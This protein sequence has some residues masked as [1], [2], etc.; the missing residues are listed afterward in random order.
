M[1]THSLTAEKPSATEPL[2]EITTVINPL[3]VTA[4]LA[5]AAVAAVREVLVVAEIV[6]A[7]LV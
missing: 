6:T 2:A 4:A 3:R 1:E 5:R 7:A